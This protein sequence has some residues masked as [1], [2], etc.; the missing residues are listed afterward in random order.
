MG[1]IPEQYVYNDKVFMVGDSPNTLRPTGKYPLVA[2]HEWNTLADAITFINEP[3]SSAIPGMV[4]TVV[5]DPEEENN[6]VYFVKAVGYINEEGEH[7]FGGTLHKLA[8]DEDMSGNFET[9][10]QTIN[11]LRTNIEDEI[12]EAVKYKSGVESHWLTEQIGGISG[13]LNK[14]DIGVGNKTVNEILDMLLYPTL[15]PEVTEP[16]V[17]LSYNGNDEDGE[18]ICINMDERIPDELIPVASDFVTSFDRGFVTYKNAE[19]NNDY[20]GEGAPQLSIDKLVDWFGELICTVDYNVTY[21]NGPKLLDNKGNESTIPSF[22]SSTIS[23]N[24]Y[25]HIV[26][27]IYTNNEDIKVM[28]SQGPLDY[29]SGELTF[30][31]DI[32][33]ETIKDKFTLQVPAHLKVESVYQYNSVTKNFDIDMGYMLNNKSETNLNNITYNVYKRTTDPK[34]FIGSSKYSITI[35]KQN[36]KI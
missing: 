8:Q 2:N 12:V 34:D 13:G 9:I 4:I 10:N 5:N 7:V 25:V 26:Y 3:S 30:V 33:K 14:E 15:Q 31:V 24:K 6:G 32:P 27:P 36:N 16:K 20:T 35:K 17:T 22:V 28:T 21:A 18:I 19:G 1:K 23:K 29:M 11:D